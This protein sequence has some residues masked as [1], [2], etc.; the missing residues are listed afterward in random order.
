M[1]LELQSCVRFKGWLRKKNPLSFCTPG[2]LMGS[3][4]GLS[5]MER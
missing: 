3:A 4:S 2:L 1:R 5:K